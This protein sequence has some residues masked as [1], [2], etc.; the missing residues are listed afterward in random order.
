MSEEIL[1]QLKEEREKFAKCDKDVMQGFVDLLV[2]LGVYPKSTP[3]MEKHGYTHLQMVESWG[4]DWHEWRDPLSCPHCDTDWRDQ[5][6]GP[7]FKREIGIYLPAQD[8][9]VAWKCPDCGEEIPLVT[10]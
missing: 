2:T 8:R 4:T 10:T 7:P 1:A 9:T 6:A 3:A 5:E